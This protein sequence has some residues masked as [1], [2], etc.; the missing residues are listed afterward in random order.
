[1]KARR[2]RLRRWRVSAIAIAATVVA[3]AAVPPATATVMITA[4]A[5]DE[6]R[7]RPVMGY[8]PGHGRLA[9]LTRLVSRC[10]A[11]RRLRHG[12]HRLER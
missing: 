7:G 10:Y 2:S 8:M 11:S 6:R 1:M 4:T 5:R 9:G 12:A 3:A